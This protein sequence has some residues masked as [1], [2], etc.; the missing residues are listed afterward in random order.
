MLLSWIMRF[1]LVAGNARAGLGS[2]ADGA[3]GGVITPEYYLALMTM[4]GTITGVLRAGD[5]AVRWLRQFLL[6]L[7][8]GAEDMAFHAS[9]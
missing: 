7:H 6:P 1:H 9:T 2:S 5:G 8:V 3:A 4:H